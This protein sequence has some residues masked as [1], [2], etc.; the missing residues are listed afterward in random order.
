M[1]LLGMM[2]T[3]RPIL[4]SVLRLPLAA[5]ATNLWQQRPQRLTLRR[6]RYILPYSFSSLILIHGQQAPRSNFAKVKG[7]KGKPG[8]YVPQGKATR[9]VALKDYDD[10][11][12]ELD[13]EDDYF[14]I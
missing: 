9:T 1:H 8:M 4:R 14:T 10:D 11:S 13:D 12:D 2:P 7:T 3:E 5:T 6:P